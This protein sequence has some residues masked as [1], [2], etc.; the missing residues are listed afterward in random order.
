M[1][2][3]KKGN[4]FPFT[5]GFKNGGEVKKKL[6]QSRSVKNNSEKPK[7]NR[8]KG[9]DHESITT[10]AKGRKQDAGKGQRGDGKPIKKI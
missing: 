1:G 4:F 9:S 2:K 8:E 3:A 7:D 5:A 10:Q 6:Y